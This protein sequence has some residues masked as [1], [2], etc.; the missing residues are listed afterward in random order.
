M[1]GAG[2]HNFVNGETPPATTWNTYLMQ[3]TIMRFASATARDTA[4]SAVKAEGMTAYLDDVNTLTIYDGTA[5]REVAVAYDVWTAYTPTTTNI[6]TGTTGFSWQSAYIKI[7]KMVTWRCRLNFGTGAA[8]SGA[9]TFNLPVAQTGI[10]TCSVTMRAGGTD[11]I[12]SAATTGSTL[13]VSAIGSAGTYANRVTTG[14][15]I[16]GAWTSGDNITFTI[17]YEA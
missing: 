11:Y 15:A 16:P 3:Q 1:A 14:A 12:G 4:L 2:Y 8:V 5:W 9:A 13:V 10:A 7:G 6:T 17:T